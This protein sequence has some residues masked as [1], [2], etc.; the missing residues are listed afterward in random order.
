MS[1]PPRFAVPEYAAAH[2]RHYYP[3]TASGTDLVF[4][5]FIVTDRGARLLARWEAALGGEV[6]TSLASLLDNLSYLGRADSICEASLLDEDVSPAVE[7]NCVEANLSQFA[8]STIDLLIPTE[9][10]TLETLSL[11]TGHIRNKL[12]VLDPPHTRR[13]TY[14][15]PAATRPLATASHR[16]ASTLITAI[17]FR[18]AHPVN[19]PLAHAI[20]YT[21]AFRRAAMSIYG[22]QNDGALSTT[23]SGRSTSSPVATGHRHAH[24]LA[25]PDGERPGRDGSARFSTIVVWAPEGFDEAELRALASIRKLRGLDWIKEFRPCSVGCEGWGDLESVAP[26]LVRPS[27]S[28]TS[29]TPFAARAHKKHHRSWDDHVLRDLQRSLEASPFPSTT[30]ISLL[31]PAV[32]RFRSYRPTKEALRDARPTRFAKLEFQSPVVGPIALGALSHFG[33]G[34]FQPSPP[35]VQDDSD[36]LS[37]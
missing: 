28:F 20:V 10:A 7:W 35:S 21:D 4:D 29:C 33:L 30:S 34:L 11:S 31:E 27:T 1:A 24:Y 16:T 9:T 17:R 15:R 25:L 14:S 13:A 8:E 18:I 36:T 5:P 12:R 2:S 22:A 37:H 23:L 32:T 19:P 26:Q 3:D 6:R